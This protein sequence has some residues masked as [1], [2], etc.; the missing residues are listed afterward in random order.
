M[1][2]NR[3]LLIDLNSLLILLLTRYYI[4][5]ILFI[6]FLIT[7]SYKNIPKRSY[8]LLKILILPLLIINL[9]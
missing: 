4:R 7:R 3:Y 6:I 9:I 5:D 1:N 8:K 2:K